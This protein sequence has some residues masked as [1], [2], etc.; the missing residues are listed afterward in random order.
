M[1]T[2]PSSVATSA[3]SLASA[4]SSSSAGVSRNPTQQQP[5]MASGFNCLRNTRSMPNLAT[6]PLPDYVGIS[7]G[8]ICAHQEP[9][10]PYWLGTDGKPNYPPAPDQSGVSQ[11]P[12]LAIIRGRPLLS[13]GTLARRGLSSELSGNAR[14]QAVKHRMRIDDQYHELRK[15]AQ[16]LQELPPTTSSRPF[17]ISRLADSLVNLRNAWGDGTLAGSS[18]FIR[19]RHADANR[20]RTQLETQVK[21][22]TCALAE[23]IHGRAPRLAM[24]VL[25]IGRMALEGRGFMR[26]L[27]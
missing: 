27:G 23:Q 9:P 22:A 11:E 18:L 2:P 13:I 24:E 8:D 10:P 4:E 16:D 14:M 6:R 17:E 7:D 19:I 5:A 1:I 15:V 26:P 3:T 20:M 12:E 25:D 21:E